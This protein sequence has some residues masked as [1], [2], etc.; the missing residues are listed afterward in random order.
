MIVEGDLQVK[1]ID[2]THMV[3]F[4][5]VRLDKDIAGRSYDDFPGQYAGIFFLRNS[6]GTLE[7]L[8]MRNS[9]Y[10]INVGNIKTTGNSDADIWELKNMSALNAPH[11]TIRNSKI[12][13]NAF[14]GIFGFNGNIVAENL[15]IYSCGKNVVGLYDGGDYNFTNCTFYTRGSAYVSHSKDPLF[16]MNNYFK[17]DA[18]SDPLK[19]D[20]AIAVFTNCIL[21]G[22]LDEEI[23]ADELIANPAKVHLDFDHC[24]VKTKLALS[25]PVFNTCKGEDPQFKDV[26]SNDYKLK[27]GSPC[28]DFSTGSPPV[29]DI[30][31][32][33]RTGAAADCGAYEFQ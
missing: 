27:A 19:A 33:P 28:I 7:Y 3:T 9:S 4:R 23:V 12:Y 11:V 6:T 13:N 21:Y 30:D 24:V 8:K 22:T 31:G 20:T 17:Y 18:T 32:F 1:G 15:L 25:A 2:T 14:Y 16:Y 10:G 26:F 29:N 5:G